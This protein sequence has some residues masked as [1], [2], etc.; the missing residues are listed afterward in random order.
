[1]GMSD[2]LVIL[3]LTVVLAFYPEQAMAGL[4]HLLAFL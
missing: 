1:M 4:P 2:V 3:L